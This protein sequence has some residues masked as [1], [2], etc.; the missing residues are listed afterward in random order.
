MSDLEQSLQD[1]FSTLDIAEE[2]QISIRTYLQ[3]IKNKDEATYRHSIRVGLKGVEVASQF[4][5]EPK[6]LLYA[7][8]LHDVGKALT[9]SS[10]LKKT[11]GFNS[12]DK[13]ELSKHPIDGYK[14]LVGVHDFTAEIILRHH[15]YGD[16]AYPKRLPKSNLDF[17][18][19]NG[20][21][22]DFYSRLLSLVDFYD[23]IYSRDNDKFGSPD[24][25]K[26]TLLGMNKDCGAII[27][28]LYDANIFDDDTQEK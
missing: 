16:T 21:M 14:L 19:G 11:E 9:D 2:Q 24:E 5:I 7:G 3:L 15:Q 23:A 13:A 26:D 8:L 18:N 22:I 25:K 10:S 27:R 17:S 1:T 28:K 6:V 4:G 20:V 12:K